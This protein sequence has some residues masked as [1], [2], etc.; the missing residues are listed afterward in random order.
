MGVM[1]PAGMSP[2]SS[3]AGDRH[4]LC[5]HFD[6]RMTCKAALR[7]CCKLAISRTSSY[8]CAHASS[9][10]GS[11]CLTS[12]CS[13]AHV[14]VI[15]PLPAHLSYLTVPS[16]I[17]GLSVVPVR[18]RFS[19][20]VMVTTVHQCRPACTDH[21]DARVSSFQNSASSPASRRVPS[22]NRWPLPSHA[23]PTKTEFHRGYTHT[24][25]HPPLDKNTDTRPCTPARPCEAVDCHNTMAVTALDRLLEDALDLTDALDR[26]Q[27]DVLVTQLHDHTAQQR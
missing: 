5:L 18:V 1:V 19:C 24:T 14:L 16:L 11:H 7:G 12:T 9:R 23:Q 22:A 3:P 2:N 27:V 13:P 21:A 25:H 10:A 8:V 6:C 15:C 4:Y 26:R 17:P 20:T